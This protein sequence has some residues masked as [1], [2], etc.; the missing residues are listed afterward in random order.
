MPP[1]PPAA[2]RRP[3]A[4]TAHGD[5]RIDD[6][7]WLR[8]DDRDDPEVLALLEAENDFVNASLAHTQPLQE[9]LFTEMKARIKETDLS[10]P[11][12]KDGRWFYSRT[13]EGKQYP[14]LCRTSIE[15]LADRPDGAEVPGEAVLLDMNVLAGDSDYFGMGAYDLAPDQ[16]LLLYSTDHDG[17]ERYTMRVR[18]LQRGVDLPE[19]IHD[20]TY[21]TA[22]AGDDVFFYVR[23]DAAMRPHQVW[24]HEIGSDPAD[25][26]LVYEDLDERFFVSVGLSLTERWVHISTSSKVTSEEHL[27]PVDDPR[28]APRC[29]QP[30][31]QDVEYD[32]THAP[33]PT[34]GDRFLVLTNADGAVN[35]K[36][37]SA[38]V[39]QPDRAHWTEVVPHRPDVKLEGVTAFAAHLIRYERREGV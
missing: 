15:P 7:Y 10:V 9:A 31:E 16:R 33:N 32:V 24:R 20:T 29:V 38:P 13:E 12:R 39:D 17:S 2:P 36:L 1:S 8:S 4:L 28:S 34:D 26:E 23:Q 27:I 30:R 35:F 25:D 14:I 6:W 18:D 19:V 22:W 3:H 21:G 11:F 37:M 5:T